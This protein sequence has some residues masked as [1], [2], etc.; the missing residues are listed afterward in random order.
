MKENFLEFLPDDATFSDMITRLNSISGEPRAS[1][2][3]TQLYM[4]QLLNG[5][6]LKK[7]PKPNKLVKK[8]FNDKIDL[9]ESLNY[10]PDDLIHDIKKVKDIRN[11]FAHKIKTES[12]QFQHEFMQLVKS[13]IFARGIGITKE[14][15]AYN[16]YSLIMLRLYRQTRVF[17]KALYLR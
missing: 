11:L 17:V 8:T 13:M 16:A 12:K 4:E 7:F 15:T 2:L 3:I 9:V 6:I 1:V 10:L 14:W 5:I